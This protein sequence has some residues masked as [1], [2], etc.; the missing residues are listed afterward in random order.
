MLRKGI[1]HFLAQRWCCICSHHYPWPVHPCSR[2]RH[3]DYS[4]H[5][6]CT[7]QWALLASVPCSLSSPACI[8]IQKTTPNSVAYKNNHLF[9]HMFGFG[10]S[11][12][13]SAGLDFR[14][15]TESIFSL[16]VFFILLRPPGLSCMSF[17]SRGR[18]TR[19]GPT[20]QAHF[21]SLLVPHV[22]IPPQAKQVNDQAH[23]QWG[24][25]VHVT[26]EGH[27]WDL[28]RRGRECLPNDNLI[29]LEV[30]I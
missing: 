29:H 28:G 12:L 19:M 6:V 10:W 27:G 22:T 23:H 30:Q 9:P 16:C 14:L 2:G 7:S 3:C 11:S 13:R 17:S 26:M 25:E 4:L 21:Q 24:S 8:C 20:A 15:Q 18:S 5:L 1:F